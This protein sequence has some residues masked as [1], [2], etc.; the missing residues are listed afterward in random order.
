MGAKDKNEGSARGRQHAFDMECMRLGLK[1][2]GYEQV[3][4]RMF[5]K[6][7]VITGMSIRHPQEEGEDSLVILKAVVSGESMV[8]FHAAS[9]LHEVLEGLMNRLQNASLKWKEDQYA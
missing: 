7:V 9:S 6:E 1:L 4:D 2:R 3:L 5:D 8:A